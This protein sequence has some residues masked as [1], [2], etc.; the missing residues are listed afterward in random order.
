[1]EGDIWE[2]TYKECRASGDVQSAMFSLPM[3]TLGMCVCVC[4][5]VCGYKYVCACVHSHGVFYTIDER[6]V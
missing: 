5:C 3:C 4:V 6:K 2:V 1:M